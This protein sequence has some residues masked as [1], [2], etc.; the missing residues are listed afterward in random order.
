MKRVQDGPH[1][2]LKIIFHRD[3][4]QEDSR[5]HEKA[6]HQRGGTW[7]SPRSTDPTLGRLTQVGPT[8]QLPSQ[9]G[10]PPPYGFHLYR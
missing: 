6:S 4:S 8:C 7:H 3:P 10:F 9:V 1:V 5:E 2:R